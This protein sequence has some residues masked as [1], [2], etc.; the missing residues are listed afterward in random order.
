LAAL[1]ELSRSEQGELAT[2]WRTCI[3]RSAYLVSV[4]VILAGVMT[5]LMIK[6]MPEYNAIF[7]EFDIELPVLTALAI[8]FSNLVVSYLGVPIAWIMLVS[9]L[10]AVVMGICYLCDVPALAGLGD[11][12]FRG[13]RVADVLRILA[14]AT[15]H[16]QPLPHVLGRLAVVFPSATI[17]RRLVPAAQ[18]VAA[19]DD[20]REALRKVRLITS[21]EQ[22]LLTTAER[23]GNVPWALRAIAGRR[24]KKAVYRLA[25]ALQVLYPAAVLMLGV[26]VGFF[27]VSLFMPIVVLIRGLS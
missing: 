11:W 26:L 13:R 12:L 27:V 17:H 24:E 8:E 22:S 21:A 20:W 7:G 3:D 18:M 10:A 15:E 5:F 6:I 4:L 16:R 14:I 19:G 25:A 23:V 9:I 2:I 1:K